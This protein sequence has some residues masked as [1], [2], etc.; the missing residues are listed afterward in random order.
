[1]ALDQRHAKVGRYTISY[2]RLD[3]SLESTGAADEAR[4]RRNARRAARDGT[5]A[6][7]I[8][9]YNSYVSKVTIPILNRAGIAQISPSNT[10][11]GLTSRA[12]GHERGEP[13][14]FY[15]TGRRTYARLIPNDTLQAAALVTIARND[16]CASVHV[17]K[18][19]T[20]YSEGLSRTIGRTARRAGLKI[21][22]TQRYDPYA[23]SYRSL[24]RGVHAPCVIQTGEIEWSGLR[25]LRAVAGAHRGVHL[26]GA[27][28]VCLN[29]SSDPYRGVPRSVAA[30]RYRCTIAVREPFSRNKRARRF[31]DRYAKRYDERHPD[32]YAVYGYEAMKVLLASIDRARGPR[33]RVTRRRIVKAVFATAKHDSVLG[34]YRIRP[35]GDITTREYGVYRI[36]HRYLKFDHT[37]TSVR[38]VVTRAR[39]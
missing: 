6:G 5:T 4:G 1:M 34:P 20:T 7:Y 9:E 36:S 23:R 39:R 33:G 22:R 15:P 37:V 3:D 10:Y 30:R 25:V 38:P 26:Y 18:S 11:V 17:L 14:K 21:R 32:P 2:K 29:Q 8:G 27:D 13:R 24:A 16:G 28:G 35:N 19:G 31:Y 12:P